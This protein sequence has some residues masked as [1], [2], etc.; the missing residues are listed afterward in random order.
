M[1]LNRVLRRLREVRQERYQFMRGFFPGATDEEAADGE[2]PRLRTIVIGASGASVGKTLGSLNLE[3][4][5]VQVT[6]VRRTGSRDV[7]PS[8]ELRVQQG[9]V[10]VLLGT[11]PDPRYKPRS[12]SSAGLEMGSGDILSRPYFFWGRP[13]DLIA[14]RV[15]R[16]RAARAAMNCPSPSA[17]FLARLL[18]IAS[19]SQPCNGQSN[20]AMSDARDT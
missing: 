13:G 11:Q 12:A 14:P 4:L 15:C 8:P 5:G 20:S 10:L 7:N 6:A 9:D 16:S 17:R 18:G 1:P 3:S 19:S 2:Q